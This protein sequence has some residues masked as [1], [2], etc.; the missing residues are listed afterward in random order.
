MASLVGEERSAQGLVA[1]AATAVLPLHLDHPVVAAEGLVELRAIRGR[2]RGTEFEVA[3]VRILVAAGIKP[4]I[5]VGISDG[6]FGLMGDDVGHSVRAAHASRRA[7]R[8]GGLDFAA[9]LALINVADKGVLNIG[10]ADGGMRVETTVGAAETRAF[11]DVRRGQH[12]VNAVGIQRQVMPG[13]GGNDGGEVSITKSRSLGVV[14]EHCPREI[15]VPAHVSGIVAVRGVDRLVAG[16]AQRVAAQETLDQIDG[17][18]AVRR[19]S[20][21]VPV[22]VPDDVDRNR[23]AIEYRTAVIVDAVALNYGAAA[24]SRWQRPAGLTVPAVRNLVAAIARTLRNEGVGDEYHKQ[25]NQSRFHLSLGSFHCYDLEV[26]DF[27]I[28]SGRTNR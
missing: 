25:E 12:K 26:L 7:V 28:L 16:A 3:L 19:T 8:A 10:A 27:A 13:V 24:W 9:A 4:G 14:I 1:T 5:Q 18:L 6:F 17:R 11:F 22:A 15:Q 23:I 2:L 21:T 20:A